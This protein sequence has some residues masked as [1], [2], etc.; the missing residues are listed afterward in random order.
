MSETT[1]RNIGKGIWVFERP[2]RLFGAEFGNRM[3]V[4]KL[5]ND[6][7]LLHSPIA[8]DQTVKEQIEALGR[9]AY[10]ITPNA[11]HGL[12][13]DEWRAAFPK[14]KHR[15]AKSDMQRGASSMNLSDCSELPLLPS[16]IEMIQVQGAPKANEFLFFHTPSRTLIVTDLAFN[17]GGDVSLWTKIFFSLNDSYG[18]F[19]PSRLMRSMVEDQS[20][21]RDSLLKIFEW[22][23][24]QIVVSHGLVVERNG[25]EV[26]RD[27][28]QHYLTITSGQRKTTPMHTPIRCG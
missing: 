26:M 21:L 5:A 22:D 8:L 17:I 3:S 1:I 14:A 25:K 23:F 20:A 24:D 16:E 19:G 11:F 6:E 13:V 4:I 10:L 15:T 12:Y 2:F 28:F 9:V 18:K 27:A 7:L